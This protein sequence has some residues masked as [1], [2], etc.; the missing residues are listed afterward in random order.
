MSLSRLDVV[1]LDNIEDTGLIA[2]VN[3]LYPE[4]MPIGKAHSIFDEA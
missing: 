3:A 2:A 4:A 1:D